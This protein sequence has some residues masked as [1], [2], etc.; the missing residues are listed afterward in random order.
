MK[1]PW[2]RLAMLTVPM[3]SLE[4]PLE[5]LVMLVVPLVQ[6]QERLLPHWKRIVLSF[7]LTFLVFAAMMLDV[8]LRTEVPLL[9]NERLM[10]PN[11]RLMLPYERLMLPYELSQ[12][13]LVQSHEP[14]ELPFLVFV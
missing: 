1:L 8:W 12:D 6:S 14:L 3:A 2:E 11:E 9:P 5:R 4:L 10:L 7:E 13:M